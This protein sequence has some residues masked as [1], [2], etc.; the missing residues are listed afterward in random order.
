MPNS[1]AG[2]SYFTVRPTDL[3]ADRSITGAA[4]INVGNNAE[5]HLEHVVDPSTPFTSQQAY[6]DL[7]RK[8]CKEYLLTEAADKILNGTKSL[9]LHHSSNCKFL[10]DQA[11]NLFVL[12]QMPEFTSSRSLKTAQKEFRKLINGYS[13]DNKQSIAGFR[14]GKSGPFNAGKNIN[15]LISAVLGEHKDVFKKVSGELHKNYLRDGLVKSLAER[16]GGTPSPQDAIDSSTFGNASHSAT[17]CL[18]ELLQ[19]N[20]DQN[21][22]EGL[23]SFIKHMLLQLDLHRPEESARPAKK[24]Q[25]GHTQRGGAQ[26]RAGNARP[27]DSMS[28]TNRSGDVTGAPIDIKI[29]GLGPASSNEVPNGVYLAFIRTIDRLVD[30]LVRVQDRELNSRDQQQ[31]NFYDHRV[32]DTRRGSNYHQ[33]NTQPPIIGSDSGCGAEE[34]PVEVTAGSEVRVQNWVNSSNARPVNT[35]T[36]SPLPSELD[37]AD[38]LARDM[39]P[40]ATASDNLGGGILEADSSVV[41]TVG[42]ADPAMPSVER[43]QQGSDYDQVNTLQPIIG[44]ESSYGAEQ[45]PVEA[46]DE[47]VERAQNGVSESNELHINIPAPPP[48]PTASNMARGAGSMFLDA[49]AI[50]NYERVAEQLHNLPN[51]RNDAVRSEATTGVQQNAMSEASPRLGRVAAPSSASVSNALTFRRENSDL[52]ENRARRPSQSESVSSIGSDS[53]TQ[54]DQ[55]DSSLSR[56]LGNAPVSPQNAIDLNAPAASAKR[57]S[58]EIKIDNLPSATVFIASRIPIRNKSEMSSQEKSFYEQAAS[59]IQG[60]GADAQLLKNFIKEGRD[61]TRTDAGVIHELY[62]QAC[63]ESPA[64]GVRFKSLYS[65][66]H[67]EKILSKDALHAKTAN[68]PLEGVAPFEVGSFRGSRSAQEAGGTRQI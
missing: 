4:L 43:M 68:R 12:S 36:P 21:D 56:D 8:A 5:V 30:E 7:G 26:D 19:Q 52:G 1:V 11:I 51:R 24:S 23:A 62:T 38:R 37:S 47:S 6:S 29:D 40:D 60:F 15:R 32:G 34:H 35:P 17:S 14:V 67:P 28:V 46:V 10:V 66:L 3:S 41:A 65:K 9:D 57:Q 50:A 31:R 20:I 33:V 22:S 53:S 13:H 59:A 64:F 27:A 25:A 54:T 61:P 63:K 49:T 58:F 44:S 42:R 55:L 18:S 2:S 45:S 48:L 39:F 16:H